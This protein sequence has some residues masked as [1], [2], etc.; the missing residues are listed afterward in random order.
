MKI[1]EAEVRRVQYDMI[2]KRVVD[3]FRIE[4]LFKE[5]DMVIWCSCKKGIFRWELVISR[6]LR[7]MVHAP[8]SILLKI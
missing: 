7:N 8:F 3:K 4:E 6:S 5:E 1:S 2:Y